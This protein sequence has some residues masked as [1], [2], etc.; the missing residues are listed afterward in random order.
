MGRRLPE[1]EFTLNVNG[2][3]HPIRIVG[4]YAYCNVHASKTTGSMR[5]TESTLPCQVLSKGYH[6]QFIRISRGAPLASGEIPWREVLGD[7]GLLSV[8]PEYFDMFTRAVTATMADQ[9]RSLYCPSPQSLRDIVD[10]SSLGIE[11]RRY[12][13]TSPERYIDAHRHGCSYSTWIALVESGVP[14]LARPGFIDKNGEPSNLLHAIFD[15]LPRNALATII[16]MWDQVAPSVDLYGAPLRMLKAQSSRISDQERFLRSY[17]G[18]MPVCNDPEMLGHYVSIS[19]MLVAGIRSGGGDNPFWKRTFE[20]HKEYFGI[21]LPSDTAIAYADAGISP[22]EAALWMRQGIMSVESV[23]KVKD[24][25]KQH[26][27]TPHGKAAWWDQVGS[28]KTREGKLDSLPHLPRHMDHSASEDRSR[29]R[30]AMLLAAV[31]P[32]DWWQVASPLSE[33]GSRDDMDD[34]ITY[35]SL[36]I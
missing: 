25:L 26:P 10:G 33:A 30:E 12:W 32:E 35:S 11:S 13:L 28:L 34:D 31:V 29:N 3:E 14:Q 19:A 24:V 18:H 8:Q 4:R 23:M 36:S 15:A 27:G 16:S 9:I 22:H 17:F 20:S 7:N 21:G 6:S 1:Y 2:E 5:V